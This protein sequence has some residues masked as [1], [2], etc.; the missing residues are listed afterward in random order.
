M[1]TLLGE[2]TRECRTALHPRN[3]AG[4]RSRFSSLTTRTMSRR[5][6]F[7]WRGHPRICC[8]STVQRRGRRYRATELRNEGRAIYARQCSRCHGFNMNNNGLPAYDL[9]KFP[10]SERDRFVGSVRNGKLPKMPSSW[11]DV[12]SAYEIEALWIYVQAGG[13]P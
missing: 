5:R 8:H 13:G 6:H 7:F 4:Q 1:L 3:S 9:R 11:G 2:F 12:L 10:K